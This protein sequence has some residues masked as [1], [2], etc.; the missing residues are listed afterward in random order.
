M[1]MWFRS[2]RM[3]VSSM[4]VCL[5]VRVYLSAP[6][7]C[8]LNE[9]QCNNSQCIPRRWHCDGSFDCSDRSDE[10]GCPPGHIVPDDKCH[11][12]GEFRCVSSSQCIHQKWVCDADPDCED[13]SD[14]A[15]CN[16]SFSLGIFLCLRVF[17]KK[18]I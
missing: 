14:E 10:F 18:L 15:N 3:V 9:W 17:N 2:V 6:V 16:L 8:P 7:T 4:S 13:G 1:M 5:S 11:V 12:N